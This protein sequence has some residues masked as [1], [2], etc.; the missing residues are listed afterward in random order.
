MAQPTPIPAQA[1]APRHI[2]IIMDGNGRWARQRMRPRTFGHAEG[3][4]A[5]R[6]TVEAAS[7][8][9]VQY[10]TVFGFSTENWRRP[11]EEV[12]AL[13]DLLRLYVARD[14]DR[15]NK[16][17]VRI[18]IVGERDGLQRDIAGIID[19]AEAKTRANTKLN[20]TIAFNYGGQSEIAR[21][22]QRA[23][24]DVAAGK[25]AVADLTTERFAGYLDTAELP[26]PDLLIRTSG[27]SRLSNFML[28]QAAYA[29][30]VF[31]DVLWPDF[32]KSSLEEA[33]EQYRRRDRRFGGSDSEPA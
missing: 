18:R 20:L 4:E 21:A 13:F 31:L 14:L 32:N 2:A 5:L 1:P 33:I 19:D 3:V 27:E 28:W 9:G 30:L 8:L 29:E 15:L 23:A 17:G 11:V 6:R 24:V 10:L 26:P 12:N 7:E 25:L 22:A 16:N